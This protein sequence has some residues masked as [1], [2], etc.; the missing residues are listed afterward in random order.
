MFTAAL[1]LVT[2]LA[3]PED[4][5]PP[6]PAALTSFIPY[7]GNPIFSGAGPGYWDE[8]IRER[9]W[10]LFEDGE[11]RMWY[12]SYTEGG[13]MKLGYATSPNGLT[14]T[15]YPGNPIVPADHSSGILVPG[16]DGAFRFYCMHAAVSLYFQPSSDDSEGIQ[17]KKQ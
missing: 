4:A 17:T 1:F 14:W 3:A 12:T 9:G 11:Y 7:A 5:P 15:R 2:C 13:P 8:K 10:I 16:A 6:F